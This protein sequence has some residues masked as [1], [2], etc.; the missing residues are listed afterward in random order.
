MTL[1]EPLLAAA[2]ERRLIPFI[3]AGFSRV[4]DLPSWSDV[5]DMVAE[6]VDFDPEIAS[7]YGDFLQ[8]AE[9]LKIRENGLG[10]L[11]SDLDKLLNSEAID[12]STSAAHM[13]IPELQSQTLYTTNWDNLIERSFQYKKKEI[14]KIVTVDDLRKANPDLPSIVKLH[15][16][17]SGDDDSIVFTE[18]SYFER[19][20]FESPLDIRLRSDML[21]NVLLFVGYSM[22]DVNIRYMW[23]KLQKLLATQQST[24]RRKHFAYIIA[25]KR[26]PVFEAICEHSRDIGVLFLDPLEPQGSLISLLEDLATQANPSGAA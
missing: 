3:G 6:K 12:V 10:S 23:F 9:Y 13:L 2:R 25:T 8:L 24:M 7:L 16:D 1:P 14:N 19:L 4:F 11:R 18:S 22:S 26:N 17:F 20:N 15:G 5:I 21:G